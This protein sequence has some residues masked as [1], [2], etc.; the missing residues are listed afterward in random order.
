MRPAVAVWKERKPHAQL[1]CDF[2][3][4]ETSPITTS[5]IIPFKHPSLSVFTRGYFSDSDREVDIEGSDKDSIEAKEIL[6]FLNYP[7]VPLEQ[8]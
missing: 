7:F 4:D 1:V 5:A 3:K 2:P 6:M 8:P